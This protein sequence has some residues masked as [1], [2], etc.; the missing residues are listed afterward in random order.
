M[1]TCALPPNPPTPV[2]LLSDPPLIFNPFLGLENLELILEI[3]TSLKMLSIAV[4]LITSLCG[5]LED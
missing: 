1:L 2:N 5:H 4:T 3:F